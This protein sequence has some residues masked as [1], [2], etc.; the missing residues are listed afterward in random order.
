MLG[1]SQQAMAEI[2]ALAQLN[3]QVLDN[4][5]F[6]QQVRNIADAYGLDK[7]VVIDM[8]D[9]QR[10]RQ[11]RAQQQAAMQQQAMQLQGLE[12]GSKAL[13]NVAKV[14]PEMMEQAQGAMQ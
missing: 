12:V 13:A 6:D 1:S 3:P 14:P 11:A 10:L 5:D 8:A 7:R 4:I 2:V 9:V